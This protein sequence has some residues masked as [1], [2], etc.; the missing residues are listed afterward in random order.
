MDSCFHGV[1]LCMGNV[2]ASSCPE[3]VEGR[4]KQG[5]QVRLCVK[6]CGELFLDIDEDEEAVKQAKLLG[7]TIMGVEPEPQQPAGNG[8]RSCEVD[9]YCEFS[10]AYL[11]PATAHTRNQHPAKADVKPG[12]RLY[13]NGY[14]VRLMGAYVAYTA[15]HHNKPT[16]A[17]LFKPYADAAYHNW[18]EQVEESG[19]GGEDKPNITMTRSRLG[20][21]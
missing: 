13:S 14:E 16:K 18:A 3:V 10:A 2:Y 12:V 20:W 1:D 15:E 5:D 8:P 6:H 9:T 7:V 11:D 17:E 4:L 21:G 19:G